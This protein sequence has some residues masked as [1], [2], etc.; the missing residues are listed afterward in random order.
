M[1]FIGKNVMDHAT[2]WCKVHVPP[3]NELT[4]CSTTCQHELQAGDTRSHHEAAAAVKHSGPST[5]ENLLG[6]RIMGSVT[7]SPFEQ[8]HEQVNLTK[9]EIEEQIR[10]EIISEI[11]QNKSNKL[12]QNAIQGEIGTTIH[13]SSAALQSPY[14]QVTTEELNKLIK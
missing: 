7:R 8:N 10:N 9:S 1:D 14:V 3:D 4:E 2:R 5:T 13:R 11:L 12:V 6:L